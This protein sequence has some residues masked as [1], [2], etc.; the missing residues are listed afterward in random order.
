MPSFLKTLSCVVVLLGVNVYMSL[1][2]FVTEYTRHMNSIEGA[3]VAIARF[4]LDH[5]WTLTWYPLWYGGGPFQN[6][7]PPLLHFMVAGWAE[8]TG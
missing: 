4:L 7:Y 5:D 8:L 2:L 1:E 3:Y 6:T